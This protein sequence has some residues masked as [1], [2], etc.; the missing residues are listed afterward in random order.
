MSEK[1]TGRIISG[2]GTAA[3]IP[4]IIQ[5]NQ[6]KSDLERNN[7]QEKSNPNKEEAKPHKK[8]NIGEAMESWGNKSRSKEQAKLA[9]PLEN[10]L[11]RTEKEI[12]CFENPKK[13]KKKSQKHIFRFQILC[14]SGILLI[15]LLCKLLVP[16]LYENLI[17]YFGGLIIG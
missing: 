16:Q 2:S 6:T 9:E 3:E 13:V 14:C 11:E 1:I 10:S 15:M 5:L 8:E 12:Y 17:A 7:G 4:P